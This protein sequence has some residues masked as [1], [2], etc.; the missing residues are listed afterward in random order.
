[1]I[2]GIFGIVAGAMMNVQAPNSN[3]NQPYRPQNPAVAQQSAQLPLE[4]MCK[5][6]SPSEARKL[7][8]F[9]ESKNPVAETSYVSRGALMLRDKLVLDYAVY[10]LSGYDS[11]SSSP[12]PP[13][14]YFFG[15]GISSLEMIEI[16][17]PRAENPSGYI[18]KHTDEQGRETTYF[19]AQ[20]KAGGKTIHLTGCS[21]STTQYFIK[22]AIETMHKVRVLGIARDAPKAPAQKPDTKKTKKA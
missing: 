1:M 19:Y 11:K 2:E 10:K 20:V 21:P 15:S 16:F 13:N 3:I 14:F 5:L 17:E 12:H 18:F 7:M 4:G 8:P 6:L 22:N 9:Y